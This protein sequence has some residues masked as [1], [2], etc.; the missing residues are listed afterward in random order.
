MDHNA[1]THAHVD[2]ARTLNRTHFVLNVAL[3][4]LSLFVCFMCYR[5]LLLLLL[6]PR[7]DW[8]VA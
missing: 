3:S 4:F 7:Y 5:L 8:P 1:R 6:L 2:A